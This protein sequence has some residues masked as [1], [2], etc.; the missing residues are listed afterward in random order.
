MQCFHLRVQIQKRSHAVES[1][2]FLAAPE[3]SQDHA[4]GAQM[5]E[6]SQSQADTIFNLELPKNLARKLQ[7]RPQNLNSQVLA[8]VW[9]TGTACLA[10]KLYGATLVHCA[11]CC[12]R[13]GVQVFVMV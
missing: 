7:P 2:L 9:N 3:A 5:V 4:C 8:V 11:C 1:P 6:V 10:Y 12:Q 13:S